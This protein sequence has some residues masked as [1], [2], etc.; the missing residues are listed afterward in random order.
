M[1]TPS[2][3][4]QTTG[5]PA[6]PFSHATDHGTPTPYGNSPGAP[7][8]PP[9][10]PPVPGSYGPQQPRPAAER[11]GL[12]IT[13]L[14]LGIVALLGCWIPF[15]NIGSAVV[16]IVGVVL[17][18][19]AIVKAS[20]GTVGGKVMAIVGTALSA[21][22]IALSIVISV[23]TA[24]FVTATVEEQSDVIEQSLQDAGVDPQDL[25]AIASGEATN[26]GGV[27]GF[28]E[29]YTYADGLAISVSAPEE[30]TPGEYAVGV[31]GEGTPV[32]FEV[33]IENGTGAVFDP[34]LM[35]PVVASAGTES[36]A[37]YDD[38]IDMLPSSKVQ[39]DK[40]LTYTVAYMVADPSDVQVDLEPGFLEYDTLTVTS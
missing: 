40:S 38:G 25:E 27:V 11:R 19:V 29:T 20:R 35:Y 15:L 32:V 30:F 5:Q 22:A 24:A 7:T 16:G 4:A 1:S 28:A 6:A 8:P 34:S 26:A 2:D 9:G 10:Q 18:I 36:E 31:E 33:T 14:V 23:A 21:L 37:V 39:P 17:G 13:A 3:D 12:A